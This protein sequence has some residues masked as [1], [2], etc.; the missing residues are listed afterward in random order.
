M[1]S[2]LSLNRAWRAQVTVTPEV[3]GNKINNMKE[4]K[5][6]GVDGIVLCL[7]DMMGNISVD[8]S[9]FHLTNQIVQQWQ[10]PTF[11]RTAE[12]MLHITHHIMHIHI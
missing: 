11:I 3:V 12:R 10:K 2:L 7:H 1:G 6:P 9:G 4:N 5:S 8:I